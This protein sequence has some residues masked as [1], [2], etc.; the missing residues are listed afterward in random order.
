MIAILEKASIVSK[1]KN[2]CDASKNLQFDDFQL[3]RVIPTVD[4]LLKECEALLLNLTR[5]Q[6][7]WQTVLEVR[8]Q[9]EQLMDFMYQG[10]FLLNVCFSPELAE[11]VRQASLKIARF[12]LQYHQNQTGHESLTSIRNSSVWNALPEDQQAT[13]QVYIDSNIEHGIELH[14]SE[15][16]KFNHIMEELKQLR[17][18]FSSN[19]IQATKDDSRLKDLVLNSIDCRQRE[20]AHRLL[21]TRAASGEFD[22]RI[23]CERIRQAWH[24]QARLLGYDHYSEMRLGDGLKSL[25]GTLSGIAELLK[26][27][28]ELELET[29]KV[30]ANHRYGNS[31]INLWDYKFLKEIVGEL[32]GNATDTLLRPYF[33]HEHVL[34]GLF[35]LCHQLFGIRFIPAD[36]EVSVWHDDVRYFQVSE[37]D[38]VIGSLYYDPFE[39]TGSKSDGAWER[40]MPEQC[41]GLPSGSI[42]CNFNGNHSSLMSLREVE[43]LFHEFGHFLQ[44]LFQ[45]HSGFSS[46]GNEIPSTFLQYWINHLPTLKRISCHIETG[47]PLPDSL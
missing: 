19:A 3:G 18:R 47:K 45:K 4:A 29:L 31:T 40:L 12:E 35:G 16:K 26:T 14:G 33:Q 17:I 2:P 34:K 38:Q 25:Q 5:G 22:N 24:E 23:I 1:A 6:T 42:V 39:R 20:K 44:D 46:L 10:E 37:N 21:I 13:I 9:I 36:G 8:E 11:E 32:Q 43:T 30:A 7:S 41:E 15:R 27:H 28:L